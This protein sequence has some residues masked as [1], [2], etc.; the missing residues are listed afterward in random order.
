[1]GRNYK[2]IYLV[3]GRHKALMRNLSAKTSVLA[4]HDEAK[5]VATPTPQPQEDDMTTNPTIQPQ[6]PLVKDCLNRVDPRYHNRGTLGIT[7]LSQ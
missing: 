3:L 2:H 7:K 5:V 1:M 4:V 6:T